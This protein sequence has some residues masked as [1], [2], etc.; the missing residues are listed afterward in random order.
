MLG[1]AS[2]GGSD[3]DDST[4][5]DSASDGSGSESDSEGM[6]ECRPRVLNPVENVCD[7]WVVPLY[8]VDVPDLSQTELLKSTVCTEPQDLW[9]RRDGMRLIECP[10]GCDAPCDPTRWLMVGELDNYQGLKP[11]LPQPD[12]CGRFWHVGYPGNPCTSAAFALWDP[13]GRLL[14]AAASTKVGLAA[15]EVN[16]F[17]G[18]EALDLEVTLGTSTLCAVD[19]GVNGGFTLCPRTEDRYDYNVFPLNFRFGGCSLVGKK[20][21]Q[22]REL[23]VDGIPYDLEVFRAL[24]CVAAIGGSQQVAWYLRRAS[25]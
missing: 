25:P 10:E 18:L 2:L 7:P 21:E 9:L 12:D 16:P 6:A 19:E 13:D 22:W 20:G 8:T 24:N 11:V 1:G 5:F 23:V 4:T 15:D 14:L 17:A 3:S